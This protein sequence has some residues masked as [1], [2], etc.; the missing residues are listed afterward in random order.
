MVQASHCVSILY[1]LGTQKLT[2]EAFLESWGS[3]LKNAGNFIDDVSSIKIGLVITRAYKNSLS[4][5]SSRKKV[6]MIV[7]TDKLNADPVHIGQQP[8]CTK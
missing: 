4:N 2:T 1:P 3:F 5:S 8:L 6:C 7:V